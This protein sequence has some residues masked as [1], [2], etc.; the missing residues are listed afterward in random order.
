MTSTSSAPR[1][2]RIAQRTPPGGP[3]RRRAASLLGLLALGAT[4]T[5]G[6]MSGLFVQRAGASR[7]QR[8]AS[9]ATVSGVVTGVNGT[10]L[11]LRAHPR[12]SKGRPSTVTIVLE[13]TTRYR[14]GG[15]K[16]ARRVLHDGER[17]RVRL[18]PKAPRPTALDVLVLPPQWT[19]TLGGLAHGRF[20]VSQHGRTVGH[21]LLTRTTHVRA[22]GHTTAS[23]ALHDGERVR[24]TGTLARGTITARTVTILS[25]TGRAAG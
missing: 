18:A 15:R 20:V 10:T 1:S 7:P 9:S 2:A 3:R 12:T 13:P 8:A 24:V 25:S 22:G 16:E 23:S 17:V 11:A 21:V 4:G 6:A 14:E 19:G 5:G